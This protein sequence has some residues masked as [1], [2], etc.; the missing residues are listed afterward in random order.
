MTTNADGPSAVPEKR[1]RKRRAPGTGRKRVPRPPLTSIGWREWVELPDLGVPAIKAKI[2]TGA[3]TSAVHAFD[4]EIL[5]EDGVEIVHFQIHPLQH[6]G[7]A[8]ISA[9]APLVGWRRVR[10]SSGHETQR[11]LIR[12]TLAWLDRRWPIDL[13]LTSRDE[14][15]FRMLLGRR[16]LRGQVLVDPG[17]SF[18]DRERR[19]LGRELTAAVPRRPRRT[20][21]AQ[22]EDGLIVPATDAPPASA[23]S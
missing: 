6:R 23:V 16:A 8:P 7:A 4:I 17:R 5:P 2:D 22:I 21:V 11:P 19:N 1:L 20:K 14:M 12:T 9:S 15:G 10:S 18:I 3:R 13:T